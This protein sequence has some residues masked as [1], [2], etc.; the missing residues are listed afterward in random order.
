MFFFRAREQQLFF[1][2]V[3]FCSRKWYFFRLETSAEATHGL[4]LYKHKTLNALVYSVIFIGFF[5]RVKN[6]HG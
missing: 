2:I 4:R 1:M 6:I 3:V 5:V